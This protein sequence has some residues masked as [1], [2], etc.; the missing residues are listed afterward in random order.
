LSWL[1]LIAQ[2]RGDVGYRSDGGIVEASLITNRAERSEAVSNA[3]AEANPVAEA[4]P[5]LG[6]SSKGV[7]QFRCHQL[8]L[9]R[10]VLHVIAGVSIKGG[11]G[12][13]EMV[14]LGAILLLTLTDGARPVA[15]FAWSA[16]ELPRS[17][18][19]LTF[20]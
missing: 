3:D 7:T 2:S 14:A 20:G 19:G 15:S 6:Q 4:A 12:R 8:S 9:Q 18:V 5:G 17:L 11:V 16:A 1:G 13:V 10:R